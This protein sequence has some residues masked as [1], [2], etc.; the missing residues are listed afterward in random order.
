MND[1]DD[2]IHSYSAEDMMRDGLLHDVSELAK[3]AGFRW[4]VRITSGV[5]EIVDPSEEAKS[6]GQSFEGR[7]WDVLTVARFAIKKAR[8]NSMVEFQVFF[9]N[10]PDKQHR[11]TFY[12]APDTT[13]GPAIH[14]ILPSEA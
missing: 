1:K 7:M 13:S 2:L 14:I 9:W 5:Q 8:S 12:A 10:G 4:P 3:E 11:Q 6:F